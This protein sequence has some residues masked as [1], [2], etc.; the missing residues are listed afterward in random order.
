MATPH[1]RKRASAF[2]ELERQGIDAITQ[3]GLVA[4]TVVED[5]AQVRIA[6]VTGRFDAAHAMAQVLAQADIA[7]VDHVPKAGPAAEGIVLGIR[8]EQCLPA[9]R[10]GIDALRFGVDV[11]AGEG[12]LG[13]LLPQD[14]VLF[15]AELLTPF[16]I[17]LQDFL[18][19]S[20]CSFRFVACPHVIRQM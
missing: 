12:T 14:R 10:A 1:R 11:F 2:F 6:A 5:V 13:R 20:P 3:A 9:S 4:R 18:I 8:G 19:H 16:G 15:W 17:R 7:F